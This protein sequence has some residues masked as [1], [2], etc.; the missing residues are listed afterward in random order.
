MNNLY[1][2]KGEQTS[3]KKRT[4]SFDILI[5]TTNNLVFLL[6][7]GCFSGIKQN[8]V[9]SSLVIDK[10]DLHL[11]TDLEEELMNCGELIQP[12]LAFDDSK[13]VSKMVLTTNEQGESENFDAIK[14]AFLKKEKAV[15]IKLKEQI[16]SSSRFESVGHL[17]VE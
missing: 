17:V 12:I 16:S 5:T 3:K 11:A 15:I 10:I 13:M 9:V 8:V 1:L 14:K 2:D 7:N 6:Q 4:L